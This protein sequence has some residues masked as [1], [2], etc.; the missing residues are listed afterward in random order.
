MRLEDTLKGFKGI[1][2][3]QYDD[4]PEEAFRYVGVIDQAV[5]KARKL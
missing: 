3:G 4:L 1:L 5:E 2:E